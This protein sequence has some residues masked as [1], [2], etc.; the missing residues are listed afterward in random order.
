MGT[1]SNSPSTLELSSEKLS[2]MELIRPCLPTGHTRDLLQLQDV[3]KLLPGLYSTEP[4]LLLK[5]KPTPSQACT[6]T[7]TESHDQHCQ[8]KILNILST[9]VWPVTASATK[10]YHKTLLKTLSLYW[11]K[12]LDVQYNIHLL[13][14]HDDV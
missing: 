3:A 11:R 6:P 14:V 2:E 13:C 5:F 8:N 1:A 10:L 7:T 12:L 4:Y 9:T